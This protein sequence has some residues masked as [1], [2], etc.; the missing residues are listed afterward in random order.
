MRTTTPTIWC[1]ADDGF[2]DAWTIDDYEMGASHVDGV[3]ITAT[4][5]SPGWRSD[6][7]QDLCPDHADTTRKDHRP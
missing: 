2:C 3:K 7:Q 1:D 4:V 6:D 5:R